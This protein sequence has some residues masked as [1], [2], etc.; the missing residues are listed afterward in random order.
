[1][2]IDYL[3]PNKRNSYKKVRRTLFAYTMIFQMIFTIMGLAFIGFFI[4]DYINPSS[5]LNLILTGV[6]TVLGMIV[7]VGTFIQYLKREEIYE[8]HHR[9]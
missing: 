8:K 1:M 4:G 6:G 9:D 5:D 7:S 3:E 2:E